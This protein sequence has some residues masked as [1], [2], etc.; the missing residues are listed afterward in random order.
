M[1]A[2]IRCAL[3]PS[4]RVVLLSAPLAAIAAGCASTGPD[5]AFRPLVRGACLASPG[6]MP[7]VLGS[8]VVVA[9]AGDG[10]AATGPPAPEGKE[11]GARLTAMTRELLEHRGYR[12]DPERS[13]VR[14][15]VRVETEDAGPHAARKLPEVGLESGLNRADAD[16]WAPVGVA[17][18]TRVHRR[19]VLPDRAGEGPVSG[20]LTTR[21]VT[22][23]VRLHEIQAWKGEARW[24]GGSEGPEGQLA[25]AI[26]LLVWHLPRVKEGARAFHPLEISEVVGFYRARCA[27]GPVICPALPF[28]IRFPDLETAYHQGSGSGE[29]DWSETV[30]SHSISRPEL[31]PAY[32]RVLE[33]ADRALPRGRLSPE[34]PL[35]AEL[36]RSVTLF[37]RVRDAATGDE[38]HVRI[39]AVLK[40][41]T[42]AYEVRSCEVVPPLEVRH[43]EAELAEWDAALRGWEEEERSEEEEAGEADGE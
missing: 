12:F 34:D 1:N 4:V 3:A 18:A 26:R 41:A 7:A 11:L 13:S 35:D 22:L 17:V 39:E 32:L 40:S 30:N 19:K 27:Q 16:T 5:G 25:S 20:D 8:V 38:V 24:T 43:V 33:T 14:L 29:I 9:P 31:L 6:E 28:E 10:P 2:R 37:E 21:R 36:W 42:N 15:T 23:E